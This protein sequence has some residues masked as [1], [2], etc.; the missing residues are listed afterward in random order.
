MSSQFLMTEDCGENVKLL[1]KVNVQLRCFEF[2]ES[3][4]FFYVR[5]IRLE[6]STKDS[7]IGITNYFNEYM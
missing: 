2:L 7:F 6:N 4:E 3:K 1:Y 5:E